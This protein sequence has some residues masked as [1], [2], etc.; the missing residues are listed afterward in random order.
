ME[1][2]EGTFEVLSDHVERLRTLEKTLVSPSSS[3]SDVNMGGTAMDTPSEAP[4]VELKWVGS[5]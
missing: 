5:W 1:S 4:V 3:G 2:T